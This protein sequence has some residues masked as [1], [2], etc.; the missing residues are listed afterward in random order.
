M[1]RLIGLALALCATA[2]M[3]HAGSTSGAAG[4]LDV[5]IIPGPGGGGSSFSAIVP[6]NTTSVAV[7]AS[8]GQLYSIAAFNNSTTIAYL[9]V[10]NA[11]QANTTCGSGTPTARFMIPASGGFVRPVE[12]GNAYT[13][14]IT[15][16]VTTGIADADATA[17]AAS[18]YIV[19]FT[20][21]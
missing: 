10:Y 11:T 14:A 8:P 19:N 20:Y 18:T 12:V 13:T 21:K 16:C 4:T 15:Y 6:N 3:T 9:K 17:P 7:D 2:T 5:T 1:K